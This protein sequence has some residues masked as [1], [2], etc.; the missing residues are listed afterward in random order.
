MKIPKNSR[1]EKQVHEEGYVTWNI[2]F[3]GENFPYPTKKGSLRTEPVLLPGL[4]GEG[5]IDAKNCHWMT[6][7]IFVN[8][9]A[10]DIDP[11]YYE[12]WNE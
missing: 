7:T 3:D 9:P 2:S 12:D 11:E 8:G 1:L 10:P 4:N 6:V 5:E